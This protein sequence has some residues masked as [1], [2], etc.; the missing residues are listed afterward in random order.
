MA[1]NKELE[2][3]ADHNSNNNNTPINQME[4]R[5]TMLIQMRNIDE[6]TNSMNGKIKKKTP[7]PS[8]NIET[9]NVNNNNNNMENGNNYKHKKS[10]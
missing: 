1:L 3:G 10:H 4:T 2:R 5:K 6:E 8:L 9:S 7:P